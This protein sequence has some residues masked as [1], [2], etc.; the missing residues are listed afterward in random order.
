[1][2]MMSYRGLLTFVL[3]AF[4]FTESIAQAFYAI[5]RDHDLIAS[6]GTGTSTYLGEFQNPGDVLDPY[7]SINLGIQMFP[8]PRFLENR[9]SARSEITWFKVKGTDATAD[10]DRVERNLSFVSSNWE[11][12][13]TGLLHAFKQDR[14]FYKRYVFNMYG[15]VG[16]GLL[17]M[18]PKAVYNGEKVAL[19][20]LETE[21]KHYSRFQ[22]VIPY[23]VGFKF[24]KGALYNIAIEAGWRK[25][26]TDYMDDAS[27]RGYPQPADL[28]SDLAR[29]LSD[30]RR[31]RDP[32]YPVPPG[33]G[34]RG[35]PEQNDSYMLLNIK[36]EYFLPIDLSIS[37]DRLMNVK[38]RRP[39]MR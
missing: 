25:T 36:L 37:G 31:E 17:Y 23:G 11:L 30:R 38:Q 12:N 22:F 3:V 33:R 18:N 10:D 34:V 32:D 5:R 6:V 26:F 15:M 19:Q 13:A 20:P 24:A 1:M 39:R 14:K 8:F 2:S 9:F 29:A 21:N 28:K 16:V 35:D 7:P 27:G 4:M